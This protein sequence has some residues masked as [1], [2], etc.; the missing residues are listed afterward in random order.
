MRAR[1]I[2]S[3]AALLLSAVCQA[4]PG[5]RGNFNPNGPFTVRVGEISNG[6]IETTPA[7]SSEGTVFQKGDVIRVK[8]IPAAGYSFDSGYSSRNGGFAFYTEYS[9][10]E[11]EITVGSDLYIGAS[12]VESSRIEGIRTIQNI[13]YAQPGKKALKYD[14]FIPD[15]AAGLP[16]IVIIHGG[17]WMM[18]D[19]E[20]MRGLARELAR[21][22][23]YCVFSIDYRFQN[24]RDGDEVP[25]HMQDIMGDCY[26][27]ILHIQEHCA[28]YGLDPTRLGLTGDSAGGHLAAAI[29]NDIEKVGD[30]GFGVRAGVYEVL[31][32][33]MP[34]GMTA[35][36]AREKLL[37]IKATAPSYGIFSVEGI[38]R[39]FNDLGTDEE[40]EALAPLNNIPDAAKRAIPTWLI[41]GASD[42]LI[43]DE[44]VREYYDA[45]VAAGQEA[46]Y[47]YVAGAEHA[48]YDWKPDAKTKATFDRF[49]APY[50]AAMKSF[51]DTIFY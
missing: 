44:S 6:R 9:T 38:R 43:S 31:P 14:A 17:G 37:A 12:F 29:A 30:G 10:P 42:T 35:A 4:Q 7:V 3:V 18:N 15:G 32:T 36:Q 26:G 13:V 33:Y 50:A 46:Y 22:G 23:R 41:R 47:V 49:G 5:M 51:F 8:T 39:F 19:E 16:G 1:T 40:G 2:L 21:G 24:N 11:F 28:E 45:L 34:K 20:V 48:F 27:A 25:T